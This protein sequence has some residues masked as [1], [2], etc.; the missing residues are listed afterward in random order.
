M[1]WDNAIE[2]IHAFVHGFEIGKEEWIQWGD[3]EHS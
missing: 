2:C 1:G 3:R